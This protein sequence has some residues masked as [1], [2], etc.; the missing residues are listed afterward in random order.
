MECAP[1]GQEA[2]S[3][4]CS[5]FKCDVVKEQWDQWKDCPVVI[6]SE[7]QYFSNTQLRLL[8]AGTTRDLETM[9]VAAWAI[10]HNRNQIMFESISQG[11][12]QFGIWQ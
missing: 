5:L 4:P 9:V 7:N 2:E 1:F 10:W 3:I 11:A 8:Y 12:S 6:G